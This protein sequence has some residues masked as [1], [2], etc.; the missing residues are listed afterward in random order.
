[1]IIFVSTVLRRYVWFAL[2]LKWSNSR[3]LSFV[4]SF[5]LRKNRFWLFGTRRQG[6]LASPW[7]GMTT[8]KLFDLVLMA[9]GSCVHRQSDSSR[10]V[11]MQDLDYQLKDLGFDKEKKED[12]S[13]KYFLFPGDS[14][15]VF[16]TQITVTPVGDSWQVT[17]ARSENQVGLWKMYSVVTK[18]EVHVINKV[19]NLIM[20]I[21]EQKSRTPGF[22]RRL[23]N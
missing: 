1:M 7:H 12:G 10:S 16:W 4:W 8:S 21:T 14:N 18:I 17:Y 11:A 5:H 2:G 23:C 15:K 20:E 13:F 19:N 22:L 6:M 9:C 3:D